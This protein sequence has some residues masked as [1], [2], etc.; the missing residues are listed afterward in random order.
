[1][2]FNA[3]LTL[4]VDILDGYNRHHMTEAVFKAFARA[5]KSA[6]AITG[7]AV[8]SSKGVLE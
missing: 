2:A 8:P 3:G 6:V 7:T 1:M 4:H 5:L